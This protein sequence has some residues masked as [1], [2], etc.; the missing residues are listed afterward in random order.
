MKVKERSSNLELLRIISMILIIAHHYSVHGGFIL[1][2][3][4]MNFNTVLVQML[5]IG[6]K[7]GVNIFI[8]IT[9][10]FMI[11]S[12]FK[13]KKLIKL[14]VEILCYSVSIMLFFLIFGNGVVSKE[15]I[16]DSIFPI[17][18]MTYWFATVYVL[19]Y[20][21]APYLNKMI[22]N[23]SKKEHLILIIGLVIFWSIFPS[24]FGT[25]VEFSNIGW[26]MTLYFIAS[27]IR[28]YKNELFEDYKLNRNLSFILY[29]LIIG[30][31]LFFDFMSLNNP[32][33]YSGTTFFLEMN[34]LPI[35][36]VSISMFLW[37][38]NM[39]IKNS[40]FINTLSTSMFGVYL[41]HDNFMVRN[42][43][44]HSLFKNSTFINSNYLFIHAI[45]S[46]VIVFIVSVLIDQIR[47]RFF[48]K[49]ILNLIYNLIDKIKN[50]CNKK[51]A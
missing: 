38:K 21:L 14:I 43:L 1:E 34:K 7:I 47:I 22:K 27:Y 42:F 49:R 23:I 44:W 11:N 2:H 37:F 15:G 17:I 30:I 29:A 12:N 24:A 4:V 5:S 26:F 51:R 16:V 20:L 10:Y 19:L 33:F 35:L 50:K 32:N 48:E 41:I 6:G 28:L 36:L 9:G 8:L 13:L 39:N 46:I 25:I 40:K 3:S 18:S 31:I 45:F